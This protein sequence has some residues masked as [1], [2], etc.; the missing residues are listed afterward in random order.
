MKE[1]G[2]F[3]LG[4]EVT[5]VRLRTKIGM[6]SKT[7]GA[8]PD[9]ALDDF[10]QSDKCTTADKQDIGGV[11]PDILLLRVLPPALWWHVAASAF[12]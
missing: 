10:V 4:K 1:V 12:E 7:D 2:R 3:D 6:W 11:D 9:A 8:S 5:P